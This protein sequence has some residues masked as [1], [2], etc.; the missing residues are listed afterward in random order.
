MPWPEETWW[1]V[2]QDPQ[3]DAL[4]NKAVSGNPTLHMAQARVALSRAYAES[5]HAAMLPNV[6]ADTSIVRE[7]FTELQFIPPPW[8]G[9]S[10]WN[11]KAT[12]SLA[13]DL[14]LWGRKESIWRSAINET[15]ATAAE[16]Q[17]VKLSLVTAI[18]RSYV[19]LSKEFALRDIA[20]ERLALNQLRVSIARRGLAAGIGTEM[21]VTEAEIPLPMV[22]AQIEAVNEHIAL[23]RNELAAL[24]GQGPGAGDNIFR[25][26]MVLD[27]AI[28]LP[29]ELP[30]NLI[31]RRPDVQ[32]YRWKIEAASQQIESAKAE[33]YP[34]INLLAFVGLQAIG[35]SQLI[36]SAA[37]IG[38]VGP[39]ISLP[40]FDGG[41]RRGNLSVKTA[42]YDIA[43]ENYNAALVNALQDVSDQL[44]ILQSNTRQRNEVE[45]ALVLARKSCTLAQASYGAG[46]DNYQHVLDVQ[47][48]LLA[49]KEVM[50]QLQ[51]VRLDAYAGLMRAL[52]G[53]TA[54]SGAVAA[55]PAKVVSG[56]RK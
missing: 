19:Q 7:R 33:F 42:S 26:A 36:S 43:V 2:Y 32:A 49:Q 10:D 25:P 11:N 27:A 48:A 40:I 20:E 30:A 53:G 38:G 41:R 39:A 6:G 44:V 28:G 54:D 52:G 45:S 51:S 37:G 56:K 47:T 46:L 17:Q 13:Y 1:K 3:L 35:F 23:L 9:H 15:S 34:N 55:F 8:A 31:G 12:A 29:D 18:V 22:R 14:D 21:T 5:M 24:S 16:L 4:V 50:A